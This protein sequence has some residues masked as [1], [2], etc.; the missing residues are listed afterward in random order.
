[1]CLA[2]GTP[3][4]SIALSKV[5]DDSVFI[6][7]K[8]GPCLIPAVVNISVKLSQR[9]AEVTRSLFFSYPSDSFSA[10]LTITDLVHDTEYNVTVTIFYEESGNLKSLSPEELLFATSENFFSMFLNNFPVCTKVT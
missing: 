2:S 6:T 1:M 5:T 9:T 8:V 3:S 7:A 4:Q 10:N